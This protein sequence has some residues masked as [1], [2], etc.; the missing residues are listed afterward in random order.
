VLLVHHERIYVGGD[1]S[2]IGGMA[3]NSIAALDPESGEPD[4]WNPDIGFSGT[5]GSVRALA[6]RDDVIYVGGW[7]WSVGINRREHLA[8]ISVASGLATAWDPRVT[9]PD[10]LYFGSPYVKTIELR[11]TAIFVGGHFT[12]VAAKPRSGL[13]QLDLVSGAATSWNPDAVEVSCMAVQESTIYVGGHFLT[14]GGVRRRYLAEIDLASGIPT[15]WDP[16]PNDAVLALAQQGGVIYA[17]GTFTGIGSDW[18]PR[19]NL[20]AFD[21]LTGELKDWDPNPDGYLVTA[22]AATHGRIYAGGYFSTIG[23][24][25][26]YGLASLDTLTGAAT[27]WNPTANSVVGSLA[28]AGDTL[29]VG[30]YFTTMGSQ[31]RGRLA[32]FDLNSG[33]LTSWNPNASSAVNCLAV[34]ANRVYIGGFFRSIGGIMRNRLAAVDAISGSVT[35]WD[36]S[37][38]SYVNA[39]ALAGDTLFVGGRF[40]TV[41]GQVRNRLAAVNAVTGELADWAADANSEITALTLMGDTLFVGGRFSSLDGED[42]RNLAAVTV[43]E[44]RVLPWDPEVD[45]GVWALASFSQQLYVGGSFHRA[46]HEPVS[47]L[48]AFSF[49]APDS[50]ADPM[51][52]RLALAWVAPNPVLGTASVRVEIP[53]AGLVDLHVFDLQGRRI[54]SLLRAT[55]LAAGTHDIALGAAGWSAGC[56]FL[57]LETAGAKTTRKFVVLQR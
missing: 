50:G 17:G 37:A 55:Q 3:R 38:D 8:A 4:M 45:A 53:S 56:Y 15:A 20:A 30:G 54:S 29:Y 31:S 48:T 23:G 10:D 24:Q 35:D 47:N 39:F 25:V 19:S 7:F 32:S 16:A 34:R 18:R 52:I 46:G 27:E 22:L 40:S 14:V 42:R 5:P 57:H 26:R 13:A 33:E 9:G 28:V 49:A 41:R 36:P 2:S 21:A 51:P 12:G 6:A 11:G 43:S 44:G 1:F